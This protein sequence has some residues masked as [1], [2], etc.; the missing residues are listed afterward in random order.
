MSLLFFLTLLPK[1]QILTLNDAVALALKGNHYG[2]TGARDVVSHRRA[3]P[4]DRQMGS[5][6]Q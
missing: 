4:E 5:G 6:Q 1:A 3:R 2:A